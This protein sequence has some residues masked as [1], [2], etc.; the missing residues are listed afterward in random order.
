M[1]KPSSN[2]PGRTTALRRALLIDAAA[3]GAMGLLLALAA[4]PLSGLLG[5]PIDLL[6]WPGVALVPFAALL[7]WVAPRAHVSRGLV[8]TIVAGN[9]L[10]VVASVLLLVSKLVTPTG[11][12]EVFML[13]QAVAVAVFAFLEYDGLRR[14]RAWLGLG[15]AT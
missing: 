3:S 14:D 2:Q 10:W 13:V 8:G 15:R 6:R 12:G 9:V 4:G 1:S 11:V 5:L 7:V